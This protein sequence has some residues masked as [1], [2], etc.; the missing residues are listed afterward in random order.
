MKVLKSYTQC[1]INGFTVERK[2]SQP[3]QI[4]INVSISLETKLIP[5]AMDS[6]RKEFIIFM[7]ERQEKPNLFIPRSE[8]GNG[9]GK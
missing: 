3:D 5:F 8:R 1:D 7:I 9:D 6:E 4:G 2:F